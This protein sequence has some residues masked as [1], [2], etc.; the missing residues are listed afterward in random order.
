VPKSG[1]DMISIASHYGHRSRGGD[2]PDSNRIQ[3]ALLL[4]HHHPW[5]LSLSHTHTHIY[6]FS[7]P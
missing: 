3:I 7:Q 5:S 6:N 4:A 1:D 2:N